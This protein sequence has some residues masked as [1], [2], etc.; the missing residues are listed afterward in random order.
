MIDQ[1]HINL[2]DLIPTQ[3]KKVASTNGGEYAGSCPMCGGKDRFRVQP[4]AKPNPR[5]F[6]RK[7]NERG[8]DAIGFV[9]AYRNCDFKEAVADIGLQLEQRPQQPQRQTQPQPAFHYSKEKKTSSDG[10]LWQERAHKF[11]DYAQN[12]MWSDDWNARKYLWERGFYDAT[13]KQR[14]LGWN[15][16]N[17]HDNWGLD[18]H[19]WLPRGLVIPYEFGEHAT[20]TK[21][22]IRRADWQQNDDI[23]KYIPP[24]GVKNTAYLTR[25]LLVGDYVLICEGELDAI[26]FKQEVIEPNFVAMATGGT[27]GGKL[28][29]YIAL[30]ALAKRVFVAFDCDESGEDASKY[31]IDALPNAVRL[32]PTRKDINDM[33]I[34]DESLH[35]WIRTAI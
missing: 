5:W 27:Q 13:I 14:C 24:S 35:S 28:L 4:N 32:V 33:V 1:Q 9:M 18:K 8:G 16:Q 23:G 10:K 34:A 12:Q 22:R 11:I 19:V 21:I 3:L 2:I 25:R 29:K 17:L 31:W 26:I 6:C 15:P 30:L 20:I 7:C